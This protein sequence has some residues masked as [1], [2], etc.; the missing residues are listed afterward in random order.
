M[1]QWH[2]T[3][4]FLCAVIAMAVIVFIAYGVLWYRPV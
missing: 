3:V 1:K 2:G 4:A